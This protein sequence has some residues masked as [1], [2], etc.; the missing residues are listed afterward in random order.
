MLPGF[1]ARSSLYRSRQVYAGHG[2]SSAGDVAS[3]TA[4]SVAPAAYPVPHYPK[5]VP[6][7]PWPHVFECP[8]ALT[9]CGWEVNNKWLK[10]PLHLD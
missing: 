8:P 2:A 5:A 4:L 6:Y 10:I 7:W 3:A 9:A 1:S